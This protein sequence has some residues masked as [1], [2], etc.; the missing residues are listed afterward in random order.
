MSKIDPIVRPDVNELI[1]EKLGMYPPDISEL[2]IKAIQLSE[3]LPEATVSEALQSY[4]REVTKKHRG[5]S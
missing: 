5:N 2:A 1:I 3:N 4:I